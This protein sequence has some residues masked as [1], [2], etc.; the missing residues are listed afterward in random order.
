ME[1]RTPGSG[2]EEE[3]SWPGLS[4]TNKLD[5]AGQGL[6]TREAT[7]SLDC[8]LRTSEYCVLGCLLSKLDRTGQGL[9]TRKST[10]S[11]D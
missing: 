6:D 8:E 9:D 5:R 7:R 3:E 2:V 11:L 10:R 4:I 1:P